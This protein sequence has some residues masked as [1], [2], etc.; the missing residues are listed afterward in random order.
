MSN[1]STHAPQAMALAFVRSAVKYVYVTK[2]RVE[3]LLQHNLT[4]IKPRKY[5][6]TDVSLSWDFK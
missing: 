6:S 2:H 3:V 4:E 5:C 1:K